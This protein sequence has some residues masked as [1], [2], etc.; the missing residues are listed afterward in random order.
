M[1]EQ[2]G[3]VGPPT[4]VWLNETQRNFEY[5]SEQGRGLLAEAMHALLVDTHRE[6]ILILGSLWH[7]HYDTL[8]ADPGSATRKLFGPATIEVP[9]SFTGTDLAAMRTTAAEDQRLK[10]AVDRADDGQITQYLAG[11]PE[12]IDFYEGRASRFGNR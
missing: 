12:L 4:V 9:P 8:C 1:S 7:Q 2:L 5:L 6:P 11:G 10:L 3:R